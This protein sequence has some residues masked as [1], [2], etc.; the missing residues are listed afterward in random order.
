MK[1]ILI[2][3]LF[4][5]S[6]FFYGQELQYEG[7]VKVDSLTTKEELYNRA[8]SWF[9]DTYK[10]EKD[11]MSITDKD[12][13]EISGNG[14]IRF[15]PKTFYFGSMCARGWI[16]YKI[17][18]YIKEGR[19]KYNFHTFIHEGTRCP[20]GGG[21]VSF[22]LLTSDKEHKTESNKGWREV[23]EVV[24]KHMEDLIKSLNEL[25]NKKH[26]TNNDW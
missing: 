12:L 14:A 21:L 13:G 6:T 7:V 18:I 1:Q 5:L 25:M 17:N 11:V 2:F 20:G 15:E 10:S 3:L 8:R 9:A 22:G 26:E 23:K 24:N 4:V 16:M 19:Y